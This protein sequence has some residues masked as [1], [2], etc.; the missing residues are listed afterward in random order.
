[1][2]INKNTIA[3]AVSTT[4][5]TIINK[6][7]ILGVI[8]FFQLYNFSFFTVKINKH[9]MKLMEIM[10]IQY[11]MYYTQLTIQQVANAI[12]ISGEQFLVIFP[13][14]N[15]FSSFT[16]KKKKKKLNNMNKYIYKKE[17]MEMSD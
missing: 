11:S 9:I 17:L 12:I 6:I 16:A 7:I 8:P 3:N 2:E 1:M 15:F 4:N 5:N 14:Y 13:F 10:K